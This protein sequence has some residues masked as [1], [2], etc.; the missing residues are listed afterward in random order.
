MKKVVFL[1]YVIAAIFLGL[2]NINN[3]ALFYHNTSL[4]TD[5]FANIS[6]LNSVKLIPAI[7]TNEVSIYTHGEYRPVAFVMLALFKSLLKTYFAPES[8]H[9][10]LLVFYLLC[11][12]LI[13]LIIK[14]V[15]SDFPAL[16]SSFIFFIHPF[17]ITILNDPNQICTLLGLFFSLLSIFSYLIYLTRKRFSFFLLSLIAFILGIFTSRSCA[18][19]AVF[20]ILFHHLIPVHKRVALG[21]SFYLVVMLLF[22]TLYGIGAT[23]LFIG[24]LLFVLIFILN[25]LRTKRELFS[26]LLHTSPFLFMVLVWWLVSRYVGV[27]PLYQY[28]IS[29]MDSAHILRPFQLLYIWKCFSGGYASYLLFLS[30][31]LI[32]PFLLNGEKWQ[33]IILVGFVVFFG[34]FSIR[35]SRVY[36]D[37][38]KYWENLGKR[39]EDPVIMVNLAKAYIEQN[40][41]EDAKKILYGLKYEREHLSPLLQDMINVQLGIL[42]H[43]MKEYKVSAYY[44]LQRP[45]GAL[46]GASKIAKWRLV[47]IGD[48]FFDLGYLSY[49]ENFYA[50]AL[51]LDPYDVRILRRL[52]KVLVYKNFFRAALRYFDRALELNADD[53]ES[54]L[55]AAFA[56]KLIKDK[57]G[58]E[59]HKKRW[60][61]VTGK[62]K[63]SFDKIYEKFYSFNKDKISKKLSM[64]PVVLFYTGK[65]DKR[66]IYKLDHKKYIFWEVPFEVGK[67]FYKRGK[68]DAAVAFLAYA[69]DISGEVKEVVEYLKMA[70]QKKAMPTKEEIIR[71]I[72][73][74]EMIEREMRKRGVKPWGIKR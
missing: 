35:Q 1:T 70:Q 48:F 7:F 5:S 21:I 71:A 57:E 6:L 59:Y 13:F 14:E 58:Y 45:K 28:P 39:M 51:V 12:F 38:V 53:K 69:S 43:R 33:Y 41:F 55:F 44:F 16:I 42:Y 22:M 11:A 30:P 25:T 27:K 46:P 40:R 73:E 47:P 56:S 9:L 2:L 65:T 72:K 52:G 23:F 8:L 10:F 3:K 67:Y 54:L 74:Q 49:A 34:V 32:I 18:Y 31:F 63:L 15:N 68:Y 20:I 29:Q 60:D 66:F 17:F 50:S 19:V 62:K 24:S 61:N 37:D 36:S 64:D 26:V 4:Y